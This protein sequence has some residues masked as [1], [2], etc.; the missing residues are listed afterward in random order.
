MET[1]NAMQIVEAVLFASGEPVPI[2]RLCQVLQMNQSQMKQV[3]ERLQQDYQ[4]RSSG[5]Q[6]VMLED[7]CQLCSVPAC[8]PYVRS[9]LESR[10]PPKLSRPA[11]EVLAVI[12][13]FQPVTKAYVDQIRGVDSGYTVNLLLERE[14]IEESGRMAVP[15]RPILYRT[16][17]NFLR[18]FG[19]ESLQ[20]LPKLPEDTQEG[21]RLT[22]L[23]EEAVEQYEQG[24]E[25]R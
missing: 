2:Q 17:A 8:A 5:I 14:L 7:R 25:E 24:A 19:M 23:L 3:L 10:K 4:R 20:D 18:C 1:K 16:N 6:L 22:K 11:L 12:A 13:Y 9:V 21:S 15:G